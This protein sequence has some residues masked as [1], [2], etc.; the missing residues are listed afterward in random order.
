MKKKA[1]FLVFGFIAILLLAG[2]QMRQN[3]RGG[4]G[5]NP[6]PTFTGIAPSSNPVE[7][8]ALADTPTSQPTPTEAAPTP[9][10][11]DGAVNAVKAYFN[12]LESQDFEAASK[13]VSRFSLLAAEMTAGDVAAALS[14]ERANGARWSALEVKEAQVFDPKTVLVHVTYRVASNPPATTVTPVPNAAATQDPK[15]G[16]ETTTERDELWP[17]RLENGSWLYNWQNLIDFHTLSTKEKTTAG[18]LVKPTRLTRYSDRVSLTLLVQNSTNEAIVLGQPN[19][20]LA[21]FFFGDEKVEAEKTRFIF[22]RLRSYPDTVLDVK[23]LYPRY[24]DSVEI[25]RWKNYQTPPW[26]TFLLTE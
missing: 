26:F 10:P 16:Q 7:A 8:P 25:R 21:T 13:L 23:G 20:T 3:L 2:C 24:P 22:D 4:I 6:Q 9:A 15:N 19:E 11:T 12:A 14:A 5:A 1:A 18:L 17:V